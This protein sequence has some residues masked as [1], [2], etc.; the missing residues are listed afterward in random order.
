MNQM[1]ATVILRRFHCSKISFGDV[2]LLSD[3]DLLYE[4]L[5]QQAKAVLTEQEQ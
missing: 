5:W 1:G 4:E 3:F 2:G